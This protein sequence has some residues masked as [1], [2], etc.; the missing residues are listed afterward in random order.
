[1][2]NSLHDSAIIFDYEPKRFLFSHKHKESYLPDF[3][4][5][6]FDCWIEVKGYMDKR[7]EKRL[8]LFAKEYPKEKLVLVME[9]EIERLKA[10]PRSI[11][12]I[13]YEQGVSIDEVF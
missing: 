1:M 13:M 12:W 7:S 4:L 11:I 9:D 10:N 3:Y 6:Q 5:P 2:A 8:K